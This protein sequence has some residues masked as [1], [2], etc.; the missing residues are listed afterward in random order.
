MMRTPDSDGRLELSRF[1]TP[2]TVADHYAA[3]PYFDRPSATISFSLITSPG[4]LS[5]SRAPA[6]IARQSR[7]FFTVRPLSLA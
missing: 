1:R 7:M 3:G 4:A 2:L 5:A 6:T